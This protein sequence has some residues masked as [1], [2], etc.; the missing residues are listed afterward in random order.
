MKKNSSSTKMYPKFHSRR[1]V[2]W[3]ASREVIGL[4][5]SILLVPMIALLMS[6]V[7]PTLSKF[8]DLNPLVIA[9]VYCGAV[10][11]CA[12]VIIQL[13]RRRKRKQIK[14]E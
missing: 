3:N 8:R 4:A 11:L 14:S 6:V 12:S 7:F 5:I 2:K 13:Y 9:I 10:L 1:R